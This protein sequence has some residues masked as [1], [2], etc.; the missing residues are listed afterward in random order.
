MIYRFIFKLKTESKID[1]VK[2]ENDTNALLTN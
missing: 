1:V 2:T